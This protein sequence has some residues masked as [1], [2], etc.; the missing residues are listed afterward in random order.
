MRCFYHNDRDA[1]GT[2][3][4]CS[5]GLCVECAA[6]MGVALGCKGRH[7]GPARAIAVSQAK[8]SRM[9][10]AMPLFAIGMGV[11]YIAWGLLSR[12]LS[13]FMLMTGVGFAAL[14]LLMLRKGDAS[15]SQPGVGQTR[16]H[17]ARG[18]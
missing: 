2:C 14:G 10:W 5:K 8:V 17:D 6:D 4:L 12:P 1:V 15:N 13:V 16:E 9:S 7:E 3:R 11:V 18:H